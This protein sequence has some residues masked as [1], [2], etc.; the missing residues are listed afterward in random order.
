[1]K[2]VKCKEAIWCKGNAVDT[3]VLVK[4]ENGDEY[5]VKPWHS[6]SKNDKNTTPAYNF[7]NSLRPII[8]EKIASYFSF[9]EFCPGAVVKDIKDVKG[10][11]ILK[12]LDKHT[13]FGLKKLEGN[14]F[15]YQEDKEMIQNFYNFEDII[16]IL[17]LDIVL[18]FND[19]KKHNTNLFITKK[20]NLV[21]IDMDNYFTDKGNKDL[22]TFWKDDILEKSFL[23]EFLTGHRAKFRTIL[24]E[25]EKKFL[26]IPPES[27]L[28]DI[29]K[30]WIKKGGGEDVLQM[31]LTAQKHVPIA[32]NLI[33]E[34]F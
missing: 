34:K 29:P 18:S 11:N 2:Y 25:L 17:F 33:F 12:N 19:R 26:Q 9:Q 13:F 31:I 10:C 14:E 8:V 24:A 32:S 22:Q 23:V 4:T 21:M 15:K 5:F 3:R 1:M 27:L 7:C 20:N 6:F 16:R 30:S 28:K